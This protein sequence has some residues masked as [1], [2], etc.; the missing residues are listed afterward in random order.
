MTTNQCADK[1]PEIA[2]KDFLVTPSR[3]TLTYRPEL[4]ALRA[5]AVLCVVGFHFFID[6][7]PGGYIGV[8]IFFVLSGF[9]IS[10]QIY[11]ELESKK[12]S[13]GLFI[14]RRIR[15]IFPAFLVVTAFVYIVGA[16]FLF[17]DDFQYLRRS[18]IQGLA[19]YINF[20]L[21]DA[22]SYFSAAVEKTPLLH[23]WSLSIEEQFYLAFPFL[24]LVF[25]NRRFGLVLFS[26][27]GLSFLAN[28]LTLKTDPAAA[29]YLPFSRVWELLAGAALAR[30]ELLR[31]TNELKSSYAND[32]VAGLS[33]AGIAYA[34][35][36]LFGPTTSFPGFAALLP[37]ILTCTAIYSTR[38]ARYIA[39]LLA[40]KPLV[41]VGLISYPLYLVHWPLL[42]FL[43]LVEPSITYDRQF[44]LV[45]VVVSL[46][47]AS[48]LYQFVEKPLKKLHAPRV[49]TILISIWCSCLL[50]LLL[51][52]RSPFQSELTP[53]QQKILSSS[54]ATR[55]TW[56]YRDCFL[57]TTDQVA[58]DFAKF[59]SAGL[60][61]D[62]ATHVM[63][64][65][66]S[67][68]AHLYPG[69]LTTVKPPFVLSQYTAASCSPLL[70]STDFYKKC[71]EINTHV[72][73][74]I[75]RHRPA[76]IVIGSRWD[77]E[78]NRLD[79]QV[80]ATVKFLRGAGVTRIVAFGPPPVWE[81][82]LKYFLVKVTRVTNSV[83]ERL[84]PP[85]YSFNMLQAN[86]RRYAEIFKKYGVEYVSV[87][88]GLCAEGL[89]QVSV[90]ST[91]PDDLIA[92]DEDHFTKA[93]SIFL[94][95]QL[96][97][98]FSPSR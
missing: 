25:W 65:G 57:E 47:L 64:I 33:L 86:D 93:G 14:A 55:L 32:V 39:K 82:T 95:S 74:L 84:A 77:R 71:G 85:R 94:F 2:S 29:F 91:Y 7:V 45:L 21:A 15:R 23:L 22:G 13:V 68:A 88:N 69:L 26:L 46:A 5:F 44:R 37:V 60:A 35:L 59:C 66:D 18:L 3:S 72:R 11:V 78:P 34:A 56:R 20:A 24:A 17:N 79:E 6:R 96:P 97:L 12:L 28:I 10:S 31:P 43:R 40:F 53:V 89:C 70:G 16:F 42:S 76:T 48:L 58:A 81:P 27:I 4:D 87:V 52:E 54:D 30:Y 73:S 38:R 63:L 19:F 67:H 8:D 98:S 80:D 75:S 41:Y 50:F 9:L 61:P 62:P 92:I 83:P 49:S 36:Y 90:G 1:M 51:V